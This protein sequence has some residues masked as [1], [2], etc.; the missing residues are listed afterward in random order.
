MKSKTEARYA[1][2]TVAVK[3][4]V[5]RFGVIHTRRETPKKGAAYDRKVKHRGRD[6]RLLAL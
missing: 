2:I 1:P 6:A 4:P 3:P 5:P